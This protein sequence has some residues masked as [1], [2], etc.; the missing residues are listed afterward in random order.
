MK[1]LTPEP[2]HLLSPAVTVHCFW[3]ARCPEIVTD[4][5]NPPHTAGFFMPRRHP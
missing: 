4:T 5:P 2:D 1:T 3:H